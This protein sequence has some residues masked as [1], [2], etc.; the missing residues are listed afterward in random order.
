MPTSSAQCRWLSSLFLMSGWLLGATGAADFTGFES[1]RIESDEGKAT[2]RWKSAEPEAP[3]DHR[4]EL[5]YSRSADFADSQT[6]YTGPDTSTA[7]T[8]LTE[9]EH[10]YRV[11]EV[12]A[13][14]RT[15]EWSAPLVVAVKYPAK[16]A[17][18]ILMGLGMFV[19]LATVATVLRG[20]VAT[21][22]A[23]GKNA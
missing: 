9:G 10:F 21:Q 17:V 22:S 12:F 19:L 13:D 6:R 1:R 3:G 2:L 18:A 7:V 20:H 16:R 23:A 14:E 5:A 4:F 8:G 11:R 15:G